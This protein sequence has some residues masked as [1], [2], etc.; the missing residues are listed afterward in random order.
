MPFV[1]RPPTILEFWLYL[2][3][4]IAVVSFL[5]VVGLNCCELAII[6]YRRRNNKGQI[7]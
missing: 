4:A 5:T 6:L 3:G 2:V 7:K 1:D